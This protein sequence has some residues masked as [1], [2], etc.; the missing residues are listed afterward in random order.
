MF[1]TEEKVKAPLLAFLVILN[2]KIHIN[3]LANNIFL[4]IQK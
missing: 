1:V 4:F 3:Q 2:N